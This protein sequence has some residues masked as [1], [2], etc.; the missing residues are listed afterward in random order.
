MDTSTVDAAPDPHKLVAEVPVTPNRDLDLLFVVDDSPSMADKQ[1][2]LVNNFPNL[3]NTLNALP[4]G[5]PNLHLGVVTTDMGT[6]GTDSAAPGAQIG[7]LG[8]GGCA[9]TGKAGNLQTN[10]APITGSYLSDIELVDHSRVKNYTGSLASAFSTMARAGDGGCGFEQPLAAMRAALEGNAANA[11]FLRPSALLAVVFLTDEDDCSFR[12]PSMLGTDTATFGP[13]M[14]FRCT[15]FGVTCATG[16]ATPDAM[17]AVGAKAS[18]A[19][20]VGS[21]YMTDVAPYRSFLVGLKGDA[22]LVTVAGIMA[23][24]TPFAVEPRTVPGSTTP[25][26]A[27]AHS[28]TY[29]GA[30]GVEVADPPARLQAFLDLFP[31]ASATTNVCQQDLSGGLDRIGQ[32]VSRAIGSPC[33]TTPLADVDPATPGAQYDCIVEDVVGAT[34]TP[35]AACSTGAQTCWRLTSDPATCVAAD[36]L[37]LELVRAQLPDPAT[38]TRMRCVLP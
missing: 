5:L 33:L 16:G 26:S 6:K 9:G 22:R 17:N 3:I 29:T 19:G 21:V 7:Q 36:H 38:V 11:G 10:G 8:Q 12:T 18:C 20:S 32:L 31:E 4:G 34:V 23:P 24:A 14:S 2:N 28:C 25:V 15:H 30:V 1:T 27:L 37:K 35:I 13:L